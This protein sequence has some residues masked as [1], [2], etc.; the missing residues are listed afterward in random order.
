[1]IELVVTVVVAIRSDSTREARH[2]VT[3]SGLP[4]ASHGPGAWILKTLAGSPLG[5]EPHFATI[6]RTFGCGAPSS[7]QKCGSCSP[8]ATSVR[9]LRWGFPSPKE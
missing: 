7:R 2:S 9:L 1:L 5:C 4:V 3:S 8:F 6:A